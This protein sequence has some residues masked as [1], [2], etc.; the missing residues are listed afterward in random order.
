MKLLTIVG[1]R[2]QFVKAAMLSKEIAKHKDIQEII[3]HT[4]QHFDDNMSKVFFEEM[5]IPK[6]AY[7]LDINSLSH[8]AMTGRMLEEIEKVLLIEKPDM[9][10]VYGDTNSTIAGALAAVKLQIPIAHIEAG[11]RSGYYLPEEVNRQLTDRI[12][13]LLFTP[14]L[15]GNIA[16]K[17]EGIGSEKAHFVG[18]IMYDATKY[19]SKVNTAWPGVLGDDNRPYLLITLHREENVDYPEHFAAILKQIEMLAADFHMVWPIHPR[20][21]KQLQ[22]MGSY[23]LLANYCTLID[24]QPYVSTLSLISHATGVITDSGGLQKEAYYLQKPVVV[25]KERTEWPELQKTGYMTLIPPNAVSQLSVEL[26]TLI[27]TEKPD[28]MISPYGDGDA[29][30]KI[31][32]SILKYLKK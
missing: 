21:K 28:N 31:V 20:A 29:A 8:G 12:A 15:E 9:L 26:Q 3:V 32:S 19:F 7:Y 4:G 13:D 6:P 30:E 1:A 5:G 10:V 25:V 11:I 24:P 17:A 18:D 23:D 22:E 14:T 27:N 2:P 16:L